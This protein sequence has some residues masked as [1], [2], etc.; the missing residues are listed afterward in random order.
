MNLFS[1]TRSIH[2]LNSIFILIV[3][4][5]MSRISI[6]GNI[7]IIING[8]DFGYLSI[9]VEILDTFFQRLSKHQFLIHSNKNHLMFLK[10]FY[11]VVERIQNAKKILIRVFN[12]KKEFFDLLLFIVY[13]EYHYLLIGVVYY[14]LE[15][16]FSI[17]QILFFF[18]GYRYKYRLLLIVLVFVIVQFQY[19]NLEGILLSY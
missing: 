8:L 12:D 13:L 10:I 2:I 1:R 17:L 3:F 19:W 7:Y 16:N 9:K 18:S 5:H 11:C 14:F 15:C 4:I 6:I